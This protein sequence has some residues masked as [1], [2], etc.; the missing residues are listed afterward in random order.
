MKII[1]WKTLIIASLICL[2]P[3]LLGLALWERLPDTMPIH[4]DINNNPDNFASKGFCVFFFPVMMMVFEWISCII[5]DVNAYKHGRRTKFE[6]VTK[7]ILPFMC[8]VLQIATFGYSLGISVDIRRVCA[9][10]VGLMFLLIGNYL[11]KLDYV[12]NY[13]VNT[14]KARQINRFIGM[15]TVVMGIIMLLSILLPPIATVISLILLFPYALICVI[16]GIKVGLKK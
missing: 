10:I 2:L 11:P 14:E 16:Y 7:W 6:N 4:F 12:K 9:V 3:I 1:K 13:D 15:L 8:I 5:N